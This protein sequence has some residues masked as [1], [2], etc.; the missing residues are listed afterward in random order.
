MSNSWSS[1]KVFPWPIGDAFRAHCLGT[2]LTLVFAGISA[3]AEAQERTFRIQDRQYAFHFSDGIMFLGR[4]AEGVVFTGSLDYFSTSD[5]NATIVF[6]EL[7]SS[8]SPEAEAKD[9]L[10]GF[11]ER[12]AVI[13]KGK[14]YYFASFPSAGVHHLYARSK[15]GKPCLV[16]AAIESRSE[17]LVESIKADMRDGKFVKDVD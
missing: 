2:I 11:D 13:E 6:V 3:S 10:Q 12:N 17:K 9:N 7:A 5:N 14:A 15:C 16:Y 8:L 4:D 1:Q